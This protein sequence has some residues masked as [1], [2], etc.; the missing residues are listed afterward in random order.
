MVLEIENYTTINYE[1]NDMN[2]I[3]SSI[4]SRTGDINIYLKKYQT[5]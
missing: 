3:W 2:C 5:K 4:D 1:N